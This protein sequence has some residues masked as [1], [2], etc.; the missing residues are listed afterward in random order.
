LPWDDHGYR[1]EE[2]WGVSD[3]WF[4]NAAG[5]TWF[6]SYRSLLV[7]DQEQEPHTIG[8][9]VSASAE[10]VNDPWFRN[11]LSKTYLIVAVSDAERTHISLEL[12]LDEHTR[13]VRS[14]LELW[15]NGRLTAGC[16]GAVKWERVLRFVAQEASGLV[17]GSEVKLGTLPT[18]RQLEWEDL[19]E[20]LLRLA[21]YAL[22]RDR[23][24]SELKP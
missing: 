1:I 17:V 7:Y 3:L 6:G 13:R 18:D 10:L 4:G 20:P 19:Q 21:R 14:G 16:S 23:L 8:L 5:G 12:N 24:R 22:V 2:D 15:H 11:S 9:M